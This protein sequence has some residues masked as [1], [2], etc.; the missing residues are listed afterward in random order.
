MGLSKRATI[1]LAGSTAAVVTVAGVWLVF[2]G[3]TTLT[4]G[5]AQPQLSVSVT[6]SVPATTLTTTEVAPTTDAPTTTIGTTKAKPRVVA[7]VA[8]PVAAMP[9]PVK[10]PANIPVPP[11]PHVAPPPGCTATHT[12]NPAS[13]ANVQS[14]LD[15]AAGTNYWTGVANPPLVNQN[16]N[17]STSPTLGPPAVITVPTALMEAI[18]WQESGWQSDIQSCDGG[19]GT[20]QLQSA[21][22]SWMNQR[23]G[24]PYVYTT[25]SGNAAI[26]AEYIEWLIGYFGENSFNYHYDIT[27]PDMLAAVLDAYNSGAGSVQ[28]AGGHTVVSHYAATVTALMTQ[29]PWNG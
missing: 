13:H 25:L 2:G 10:P 22:A 29:Q 11:P 28:F 12:G 15:A 6:T 3:G 9:A 4:S 27:D 5:Q 23:F 7:P 16:P 1:A 8:P 21:T 20:M 17:G 14:A 24:T 18:A 26:G 19:N